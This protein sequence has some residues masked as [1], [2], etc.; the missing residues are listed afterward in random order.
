VQ[1][2]VLGKTRGE[3]FRS[4]KLTLDKFTDKTGEVYTLKELEE[5]DLIR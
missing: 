5:A 4:G 3:L 2:K 1:D